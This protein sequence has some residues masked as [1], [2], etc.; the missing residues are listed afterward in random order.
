MKMDS[1]LIAGAKGFAAELLE[2]IMQ[3]NSD[4]NVTFYDDVSDDLPDILFGSYGV[5]R[6]EAEATDYFGNRQRYFTLGVGSPALRRKF[7]D[8]FVRIGGKPKTLISPFAKVG[9]YENSVSDGVCI[10]TDAV[11]ESQNQI[12]KGCL[13]H[14]GALISHNVAVGEF[15]EISPRASLLGNTKIG[16]SCRIGAGATILPGVEVGD[17]VVIGAGSVVTKNVPAGLTV[18]GIPAKP[19]A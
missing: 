14:V 12:G 5:L 13:I 8:F 16:N 15:C 6:T 7:Y 9:K 10:L 1:I 18:V 11:V 17:N 2:T 19:I 4:A 3:I